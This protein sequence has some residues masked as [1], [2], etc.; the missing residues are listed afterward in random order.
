[1]KKKK[2]KEMFN[3]APAYYFSYSKRI[4]KVNFL[5]LVFIHQAFIEEN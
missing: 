1:M 3:K 5:T 2:N 4:F